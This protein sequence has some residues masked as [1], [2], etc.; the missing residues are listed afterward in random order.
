MRFL[1]SGSLAYDRIMNFDGVFSDH[2]L[3]EK[4]H[5]LNVSFLVKDL[6]ESFGG[7]AGNIAY[8]LALL[9]EN[10]SPI[11]TAGKDFGPYKD[12]LQASGVDTSLI[13]IDTELPTAFAS[14]IT[15]SKDNQITA[16][17]P[18]AMSKSYAL[19]DEVWKDEIIGIVSPGNPDDM[20]RVPQAFREKGITFMYDPGQQIPALSADDL[21]Q[22]ME[23]A[24]AVIS[25]DYELAMIMKKTGWNEN[26]ILQHAEIL[27]TTLGEKGSRIRTPRETIEIT[28]AQPK[29]T[30]DPTGAGDAYRAGLMYGFLKQW[31]LKISGQFASVVA[32]YTIE[33]YGTQTH[34][35]TFDDARLRYEDA[36]KEVLPK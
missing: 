13:K 1:I 24:G 23:K 29:N 18:G 7:N 11:A 30:S 25:N 34:T 8:N 10:A 9:G 15:D 3:P 21:K 28:P 35:F 36:Y 2:V 32:C 20:R 17:Y 31:P 4:T 12:W 33:T 22:G 26:Q 6:K 5:T 14:I 19:S 27:V 16:F